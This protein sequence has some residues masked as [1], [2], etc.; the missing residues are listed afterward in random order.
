M[1]ACWLVPGNAPRPKDGLHPITFPAPRI[2]ICFGP[3][4]LSKT[5]GLFSFLK[6]LIR[7]LYLFTSHPAKKCQVG[8][9][10]KER[11]LA[12]PLTRMEEALGPD[13]TH[14][15]KALPPTSWHLTTVFFLMRWI[16][17]EPIIQSEISQKDKHQYSILTHICGIWKDGNDNPICKTEKETQMYRTDF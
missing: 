5:Q 9:V 4:H 15:V 3:G 16:K 12:L 14:M 2:W 17:L 6:V 8:V 1:V 11:R 13:N 10:W 7:S